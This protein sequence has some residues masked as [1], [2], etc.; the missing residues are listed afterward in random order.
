MTRLGELPETDTGIRTMTIPV[1]VPTAAI[2]L[3]LSEEIEIVDRVR[4][5]YLGGAGETDVLVLRSREAEEYDEVMDS[6]A[7][8]TK[9]DVAELLGG[10]T[11]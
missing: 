5:E 9:R 1:D 7:S 8:M 6:I 10:D 11:P 4:V 2:E 3:G